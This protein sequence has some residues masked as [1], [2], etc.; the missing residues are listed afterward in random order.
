MRRSFLLFW[1]KRLKLKMLVDLRGALPRVEKVLRELQKDGRSAKTLRNYSDGLA[2]FCDWCKKRDYLDIDPLEKLHPFDATPQTKRRA[3]TPDEIMAL[4]AACQPNRRSAYE[5]AI[6]TGLRAGEL[7]ALRVSHLDAVRSGIH[8]EA[9]WTKNRKT[10]F[11]PL[12]KWLLNKLVNESRGKAKTEPLL[13]VSSHPGSDLEIDLKDA[14][15]AKW[16]DAGKIDF[17]ALR[18]AY[19]SLVFEA[20]ASA[21]EAQTLARH[22]TPDLTLNVYGR[23]RA[24]RLAE[25]VE[26]VGENIHPGHRNDTS[27]PEIQ[28]TDRSPRK[29]K[30]VSKL[31][32][33]LNNNGLMHTKEWWRRRESNPRPKMWSRM[34]LRA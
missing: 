34:R 24:T 29:N 11:Q 31:H 23:T 16:T 12:P 33:P 14:G 22:S 4:L 3:L 8:L 27:T 1:E 6:C 25:V 18:V 30:G 2:A 19:V 21:K 9:A 28:V 26:K 17:H 32:N 13:Y 15:I 7:K 10:G 5:T 20:G